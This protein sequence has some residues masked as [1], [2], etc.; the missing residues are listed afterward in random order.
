MDSNF[1]WK[2]AISKV[3][4]NLVTKK[5]VSSKNNKVVKDA[6]WMENADAMRLV[7]SIKDAYDKGHSEPREFDGYLHPSQLYDACVVKEFFIRTTDIDVFDTFNFY[8]NLMALAGTAAHDYFQSNIFG[9]TKLLIGG[10]KCGNCSNLIVEDGAMPDKCN[11]CG[12]MKIKYVEKVL[13][14]ESIK[15]TGKVDGVLELD[16]NVLLEMK[17]RSDAT[18]NKPLKPHTKELLQANLYMYLLDLKRCFFVFINR[19]TYDF[20]IHIVERDAVRVAKALDKIDVINNAVKSGNPPLKG[21]KIA[22]KCRKKDSGVARNC[23]FFNICWNGEFC[24]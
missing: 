2:S 8:S 17:T 12:S 21:G 15:V 18:F 13:L 20:E 1:D 9:P 24:E 6:S 5:K 4:N 19:N 16:D 11:T 7:R 10:W 22:R 3:S 23:P 14:D